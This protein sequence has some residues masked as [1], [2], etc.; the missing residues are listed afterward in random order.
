MSRIVFVLGVICASLFGTTSR[1]QWTPGANVMWTNNS[2]GIGT[3]TPTNNLDVRGGISATGSIECSN[4][5][6]LIT[7]TLAGYPYGYIVRPD[8]DNFRNLQFAC[9]GGATMDNIFLNSR[10]SF[11]YG[12]FGISTQT[13]QSRLHIEFLGDGNVQ[14]G[15]FIH[16][17]TFVTGANAFASYYIKAQDGGSGTY[18]FIV[19]GDGSTGIA[20]E[21]VPG[22]RLSV[23]GAGIFTKLVVKDNIWAD[24]VFDSA[25]RLRPLADL[26]KYI[27]D[28]HHLPDIPSA[29]SV[30]TSGVD[31]GASQTALLKKIEELTLY[32]IAQ[33]EQLQKASQQLKTED[34]H[35]R[36]ADQRYEEVC[37]RLDE[38]QQALKKQQEMI[39]RLQGLLDKKLKAD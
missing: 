28:N 36:T 8:V 23:N 39:D 18:Q 5:D 6:I 10:N 11:T 35:L 1:A 15:L 34:Q 30:A 27:R 9:V 2:V 33:D 19:H 31:L 37:R 13:P 29:D 12:N 20:T 16:T 32:T 25:Y 26:H 3:S 17:P 21:A 22:Y 7:R 14:Q 38:Q 24:Y 4:G